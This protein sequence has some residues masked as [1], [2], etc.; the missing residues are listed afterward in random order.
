MDSRREA[1]LLYPPEFLPVAKDEVGK[2]FP[3]VRPIWQFL[4]YHHDILGGADANSISVS[5]IRIYD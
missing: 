3:V 4:N 1:Q 5:Y 2:R